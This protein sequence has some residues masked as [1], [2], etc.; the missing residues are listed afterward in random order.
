[1]EGSRPLDIIDSS[2]CPRGLYFSRLGP[3]ED[4]EDLRRCPCDDPI[5]DGTGMN[6]VSIGSSGNA[7]NLTISLDKAVQRSVAHIDFARRKRLGACGG[8]VLV[9]PQTLWGR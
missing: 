3:G 4:L 1:M 2:M 6:D 8:D 9:L 5:G 7:A